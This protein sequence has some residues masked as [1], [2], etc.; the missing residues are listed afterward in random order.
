MSE[1]KT[2]DRLTASEKKAIDSKLKHQEPKLSIWRTLAYI[3][4]AVV[5]PIVAVLAVL[6]ITKLLFMPDA[7]VW[8]ITKSMFG[9]IGGIGLF[10]TMVFVIIKSLTGIRR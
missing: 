3:V 2:Y 5:F 6:G 7:G 9:W 10:V 1:T 8:Q 4:V